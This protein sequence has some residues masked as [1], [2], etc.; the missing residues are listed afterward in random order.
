MIARLLAGACA[1]LLLSGCSV[2]ALVQSESLDKRM[3]TL[4]GRVHDLEM[5]QASASPAVTQPQ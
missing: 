3:Q 5:R 1:A 2:A 4:E